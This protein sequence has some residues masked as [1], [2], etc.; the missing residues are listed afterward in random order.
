MTGKAEAATRTDDPRAT[1]APP[2]LPAAQPRWRII[3]LAAGLG[4][5]MPLATDIY[6][7]V[8]PGIARDLNATLAATQGTMAAFGLGFGLAHLFVGV[9]ADRWGRR[10]VAITS[11][12]LFLIASLAVVRAPSLEWLTAYRFVQGTFC[13]ACPI[14]SR[15]IVRDAVPGHELAR[16]Y[17]AANML[18]GIAPLVAPFLGAWAAGWGGWRAALAILA[19]Y[20]AVLVAVLIVRLPETRPVATAS[21][22]DAPTPLEAAGQIL[23]H[24]HFVLGAAAAMLIY[25]SLFTWLTTSPFLIMDQLG[26]TPTAAA[27]VYGT[28]AGVYILTNLVCA[29]WLPGH[30]PQ[31]VLVVGALLMLA[32]AMTARFALARAGIGAAGLIVATTP[33]YVG[34]G[35]A[36][37]NALQTVMRPF[38]HVAG[39]AS[40]WLGLFQQ[41]GGVA[42]SLVAVWLGAGLRAITVMIACGLALLV[43][44]LVLKRTSH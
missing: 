16:A 26:L 2:V 25:S 21:H 34:L 42:V 29:R 5:V 14:L 31:R 3:A 12:L 8:M 27:F 15:A 4:G 19:A 35:L 32:G 43:V 17:S 7:I 13:A 11:L 10:P 39:Q 36:H 18:T 41:L 20:A 24:R 30:A 33:F 37:P 23:T 38:S 44:S 22:E 28:G 9:A 40:A 1:S 6:L